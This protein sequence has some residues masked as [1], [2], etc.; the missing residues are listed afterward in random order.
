MSDRVVLNVSG[1][2]FE[3]F[4]S[5][6][7]RFPSTLLGNPAKRDLYFNHLTNEFYFE[8]HRQSFEAIL[9]YYQ[10]NGKFLIRPASVS[11]E[12]FFDEIVFFELGEK[13]INKYKKDEGYILD[14][15]AM[16]MST[17]KA[18][19]AIWLLFEQPH[20]SIFAR[21]IAI[22]SVFMVVLSIT[23]FCAET[24]PDIKMRKK[25]AKSF[26]SFLSFSVFFLI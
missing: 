3:T 10:S 24:L 5:T 15:V 1:L 21:C 8:R 25:F 22:I 14:T 13:I 7:N 17:S 23:L 6:L 26:F 11:S 19:N 2:R 12:V 20:S 16:K 9:F 18:R 4:H